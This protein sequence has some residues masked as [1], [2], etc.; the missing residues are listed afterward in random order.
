MNLKVIQPLNLPKAPLKLTK[1]DGKI[2]VWC[3]LR[4]KRLVV[5]PEEWVRQH[6]IHYFVGHLGF[7]EERLVAEMGIKVNDMIRRC[8]L[9]AVDRTGTPKLIVECKATSVPVS[10]ATLFQAGRYHK[11]LKVDY[12][13]LT[14]GLQHEFL[15]IDHQ[16]GELQKREDWEFLKEW[17]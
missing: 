10:E 1:S 9:V 11:E 7:P 3:I 13:L 14:N 5:T 8:D 6:V 15:A 17:I 4:K 16:K 2:Y 12:L